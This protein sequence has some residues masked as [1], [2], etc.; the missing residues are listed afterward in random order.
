MILSAQTIRKLCNPHNHEPLLDPFHERVRHE[1]VTFGLSAAGYDVRVEFDNKGE[2]C[3]RI[4]NPNAFML[5]STIER[6]V[7]PNDVI[8][9]VHD[10]ST[11]ARRGLAVQNTVIEPGWSG[12][13]TLELTNH[14][15]EELKIT[16]GSGIAQIVF[17]RVDVPTEQPYKGKYQAQ[18]RGPVEAIIESSDLSNAPTNGKVNVHG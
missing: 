17:H 18:K 8:G 12:W 13:L 4:L 2:W 16:R 11:W 14:S 5:A 3:H 1:G 9:I 7:M 10:K 15:P 6:F